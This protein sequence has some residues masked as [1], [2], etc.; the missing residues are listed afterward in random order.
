MRKKPRTQNSTGVDL[1]T[2]GL[3][4][5]FGREHQVTAGANG[6][7]NSL[8]S[9]GYTETADAVQW[10]NVYNHDPLKVPCPYTL[11]W[12]VY[13]PD[14][15]TTTLQYGTFA[16]TRL[17]PLEPVHVTSAAAPAGTRRRSTGSRC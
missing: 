1:Y 4:K 2:T 9:A 17:N 16:A 11:P 15:T 7:Q 14:N 12:V 3:I 8:W 5:I 13:G 10:I 6:Y